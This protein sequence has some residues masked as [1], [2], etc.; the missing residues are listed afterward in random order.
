MFQGRAS[1]VSFFG[2]FYRTLIV[3]I[4]QD[5]FFEWSLHNEGKCVLIQ[6]ASFTAVARAMYSASEDDCATHP[7]FLDFQL[8]APPAIK[9][10]KPLVDFLLVRQPPQSES[11]YLTEIMEASHRT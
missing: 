11:V 6:M 10:V 7:C 1:D 3:H 9:N 2:H 4:K 8:T 5:C